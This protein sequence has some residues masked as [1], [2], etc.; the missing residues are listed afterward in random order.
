[1]K[2]MNS[3]DNF[4]MVLEFDEYRCSSINLMNINVHR[5]IYVLLIIDA[6]YLIPKY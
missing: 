6:L 5:L 1:M 2:Y 3:F 4:V